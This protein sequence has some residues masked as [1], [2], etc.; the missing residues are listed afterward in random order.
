MITSKGLVKLGFEPS[1][2]FVLQNDGNETYIRDWN[3]SSDRPT[4]AD[5]EAA[6]AVWQAEYDAQEYARNRESEYPSIDELVVALWEGVVEERMAAVT[7][8]EGKRQ[9]VKTKYPK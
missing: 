1:I 2:D 6:H 5:I 4:T 8:L 3:S 9:A 7:S